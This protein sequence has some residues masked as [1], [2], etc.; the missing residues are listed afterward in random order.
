MPVQCCPDKCASADFTFSHEGDRVEVYSEC[1]NC[2]SK[3]KEV[4]TYS[5][6]EIVDHQSVDQ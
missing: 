5:S 1:L 4:F 6:E 3:I 2:G